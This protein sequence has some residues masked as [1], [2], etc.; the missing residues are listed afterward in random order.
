M[1]FGFLNLCWVLLTPIAR[2]H[3]SSLTHS[4]VPRSGPR[5]SLTIVA[6]EGFQN[7]C[8]WLDVRVSSVPFWRTPLVPLKSQGLDWNCLT[9][10]CSGNSC[11]CCITHEICIYFGNS[12]SFYPTYS[13]NEELMNYWDTGSNKW[14]QS[15]REVQT[16]PW[17]MIIK[18]KW[19]GMILLLPSQL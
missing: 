12:S 2:L 18:I 17:W 11:P 1:I 6:T 10:K 3:L 8:P 15:T 7:W 5:L 9:W 13:T 19:K 4:C 14:L 16:W